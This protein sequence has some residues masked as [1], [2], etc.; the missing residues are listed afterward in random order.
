MFGKLI[1]R[2]FGRGKV[3]P[4]THPVHA[5]G[6]FEYL[7]QNGD[8]LHIVGWMMMPGVIFERFDIELSGYGRTKGQ[9]I[10]RSD[11][12]TVMRI[13]PEAMTSG[14][15]LD[16]DAVEAKLDHPIGI[17]AYGIPDRAKSTR[18]DL[19]SEYYLHAVYFPEFRQLP[20]PPDHLRV[21]VSNIQSIQC[22]RGAAQ[23]HF[24]CFQEV[25]QKHLNGKVPSRFLDWGC[26]C[27]R[28]LSLASTMTH[29]GEVYGCDID[30][31]A[32]EWCQEFLPR[33]KCAVL[34]LEPPLPYPD[35]QFDLIIGY[36]VMTH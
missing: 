21:R 9:Q 1:R 6:H 34:G 4:R 32:V 14:F 31:E 5:R 13:F 22:Y 28:L 7:E 36:S 35:N 2:G 18:K 27:G 30:R 8:I 10:E 25:A 26:G 17:R 29:M 24:A 15:R 23:Q 11:V 33:T 16:V 19:A 20:A 12:H 3:E